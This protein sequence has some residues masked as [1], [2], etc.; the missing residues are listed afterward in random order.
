M[1][2]HVFR[3]KFPCLTDWFIVL[4]KETDRMEMA[5]RVK[6]WYPDIQRAFDTV[7]HMLHEQLGRIFGWTLR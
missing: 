5:E 7:N 3:H 6:L 2:Q 1:E 4:D